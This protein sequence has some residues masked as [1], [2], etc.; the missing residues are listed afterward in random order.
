MK[1]VLLMG[2]RSGEHDISLMSGAAVAEALDTLGYAHFDV[3]FERTGGARWPG[4]AGSNGE[5]LAA[6]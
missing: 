3:V 4:G 1:V 5:A 6:L 2:G